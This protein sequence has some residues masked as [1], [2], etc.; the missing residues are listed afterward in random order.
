MKQNTFS[1]DVNCCTYLLLH[2]QQDALTHNKDVNILK[3]HYI[4]NNCYIEYELSYP[5]SI[6][7]ATGAN[8]K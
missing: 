3:I 5:D 7:H 6:S 8:V 1:V 2:A 4:H